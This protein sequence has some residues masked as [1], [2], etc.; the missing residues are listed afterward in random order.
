MATASSAAACAAWTRRSSGST[1]DGEPD[2][3]SHV[4]GDLQHAC[5]ATT[6]VRDP[7]P[8][9][10]AHG[11]RSRS[12]VPARGRPAATARNSPAD[13]KKGKNFFSCV[14]TRAGP[15]GRPLAEVRPAPDSC[16]PDA[17]VPVA[18]ARQSP[19]A[20]APLADGGDVLV[21]ARSASG[22]PPSGTPGPDNT[23][24]SSVA[25]GRCVRSL[26]ASKRVVAAHAC[27]PKPAGGR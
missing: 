24:D 16:G 9:A 20:H 4:A 1:P 12:T 6:C 15:T 3:P 7:R 13:G 26:Y 22:A 8:A 10:W 17:A 11:K 5:G 18:V 25:A 21:A 19:V 23:A 27:W 2:P 14:T